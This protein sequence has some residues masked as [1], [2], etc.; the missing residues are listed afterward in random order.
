MRGGESADA[1]PAASDPAEDPV[2]I[3][4]EQLCQRMVDSVVERD[5]PRPVITARWRKDARLLLDRDR[6]PLQEALDLIDWLTQDQFWR[7]NVLGIPKFREQYGKLR[8]ARER[9]VGRH[10]GMPRA[11]ADLDEVNGAWEAIGEHYR[12]EAHGGA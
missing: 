8:L 4:V 1:D 2:R 5:E 12:Q 6:R 7:A 11:V 9:D 3:D 10:R